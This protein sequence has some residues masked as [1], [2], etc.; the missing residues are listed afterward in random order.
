MADDDAVVRDA[1]KLPWEE[2]FV[3]AHWRVR[4]EAYAAV[5]AAAGGA[6][7]ATGSPLVEFGARLQRRTWLAA[8]AACG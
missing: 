5:A 7:D 4:S 1:L 2:R 8:A 6:A 3:H